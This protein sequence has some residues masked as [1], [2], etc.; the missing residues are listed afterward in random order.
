MRNYALDAMK[1]VGII[2]VVIFHVIDRNTSAAST[3]SNGL[4]NMIAQFFMLMFL[5]I[6]G[7]VSYGKVSNGTWVKH[8]AV[9]WSIPIAAFLFIYY[10]WVVI[11]PDFIGMSVPAF[12]EYLKV[13]IFNGMN[14]LVTWY[15]WCLV[16]CYLVGYLIEN[17]RM[18]V[19]VPLYVIIPAAILIINFAI[20]IDYFGLTALKWGI[21]FYLAGYGIRHY[22]ETKTVKVLG[23]AALSCIVLYPVAGYITHWMIPYQ[24]LD[25][26]RLGEGFMFSG[27]VSGNADKLLLYIGMTILGIGCAYSFVK[28]IKCRITERIVQ[29]MN[30]RITCIYLT[31][32]LFV[33]MINN[34]AL[35][36]IVTLG[37]SLILYEGIS[38]IKYVKYI[39][40]N[41]PKNKTMDVEYYESSN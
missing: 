3:A 30:K 40:G 4:F 31:H 36:S 37:I 13:E 33:G 17:L 1:V 14:G 15:L 38:R 26:G 2:L 35:G 21:I 24:S 39:L 12:G 32:I 6:S 25:Y 23:I 19:K 34:I 11:L 8:K 18:K 22:K 16:L 9:Q 28:L 7:Y 27:I 29:F 5:A 20:Y 10:A 41:L